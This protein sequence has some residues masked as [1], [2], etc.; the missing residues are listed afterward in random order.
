MQIGS[1]TAYLSYIMQILGNVMMAVMMSL[2]IPRAAASAE[3]LASVFD[4][5]PIIEDSVKEIRPVVTGLVEFKN[6]EFRYPGAEQPIL[7]N[8]T[9]DAQPGQFTAIVGSTGSG[10]S[11]LINLIPRLI[12]VSAGSICVNGVDV[13]DQKLETLWSSMGIVPQRSLLFKGT[14]RSNIEF[15]KADATDELIW[16]A[17]EIAQAT[18]FVT[19]L[20]EQLDAPVAQGGSN[21]SGG[22][23]QRLS[24]ARALI[25]SPH[26][27]ILDDSFSALDFTTDAKLRQALHDYASHATLIVVAQRVSTIMQADQIIVL[28]EGR[29][30]GKGTHAELMQSSET[31]K[32]I[33][34]SQLSP[35]EAM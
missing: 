23:R 21:F 14:I 22:Q 9:F 13:R 17:L 29:I 15:G 12:E 20:P 19:S 24:I 10:K 8:I 25:R 32:E 28:D 30:V 34:L 2:M 6:V 33:V 1:L 31:Y 5:Q 7:S 4:L 16:S 18:D 11:T 27:Y 35:E 26:I 3:R